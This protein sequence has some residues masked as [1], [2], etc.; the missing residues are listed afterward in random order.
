MSMFLPWLQNDSRR[1]SKGLFRAFSCLGHQMAPGG[2]EK[3]HFEHFPALAAKWP[4]KALR[5]S[6]LSI[7]LPWLQNGPWRPS[8]GLFRA[9]SCLGCKMSP[10]NFQ[11]AH[12]EHFHALATKCLCFCLCFSLCLRSCLCLCF[13]LCLTSCKCVQQ[14]IMRKVLRDIALQMSW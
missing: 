7:F 9:F 3:V 8:E 12:L 1:L 11:K 6:I 14:D 13:C 5:K 10:E 4:L 2:L